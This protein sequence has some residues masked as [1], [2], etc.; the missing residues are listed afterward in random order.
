M[1]LSAKSAG[2]TNSYTILIASA[3][4]F[5]PQEDI[6]AAAFR[7]LDAGQAKGFEAMER[8]TAEWWHA[9]WRRGFV[10]LAS[11]DGAANYVEQNYTYFLYLMGASSRGKYPPKFNGMIFNTGG[12]FRSWGSQHWF[13]NLSCYY[14]ALFATNRFELMDPMF[15]M[16]FAMLPA[17]SVAARQE[18][19]SQGMYIPE[20]VYFDGL[21]K[22]PDDIAAEMAPFTCCRSRGSSARRDSWSSRRPNCRIP[23]AGTGSKAEA[24]STVDG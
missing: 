7:L 9:F 2:A 8:E 20:T 18:W 14:E 17:S 10:Q 13:A 5:D 1:G 19:N 16:Y 21:E 22:L 6:A 3:A 4:T 24:G 23:A 15:D 12:D 11:A